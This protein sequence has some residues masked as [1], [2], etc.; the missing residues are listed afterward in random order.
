VVEHNSDRR[1]TLIEPAAH[2]YSVDLP[3]PQMTGIMPTVLTLEERSR[4]AEADAKLLKRIE[5]AKLRGDDREVRKLIKLRAR[6]R[7]AFITSA[8]R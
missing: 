1:V 5:K 4:C 8:S 7:A 2:L 6:S 3:V